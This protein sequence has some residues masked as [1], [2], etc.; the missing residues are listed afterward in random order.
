MAVNKVVGIGILTG[1]AILIA[2]RSR[3]AKASVEELLK[4][5]V[6]IYNSAKDI[7]EGETGLVLFGDT[8]FEATTYHN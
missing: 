4:Q 2:S 1:V 6:P 3:N 7:P 8:Y 5:G